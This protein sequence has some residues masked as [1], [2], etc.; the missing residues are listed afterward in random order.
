MKKDNTDVLE[1]EQIIYKDKFISFDGTNELFAE[2]EE[3]KCFDC[4][5]TIKEGICFCNREEPKQETL[6]EAAKEFFRKFK[7]TH[8]PDNYY[9]ALVEFA[10]WNQER[11]YSEEDMIEFAQIYLSKRNDNPRMSNK[12]IF[13]LWF[14]QFKKK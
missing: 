7:H 5:G 1:L 12:D 2:K 8:S 10:K 13:N 4:Q 6:E 3:P 11:I 14:E 9:L